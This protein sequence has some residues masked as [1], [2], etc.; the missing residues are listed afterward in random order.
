MRRKTS[1]GIFRPRNVAIDDDRPPILRLLQD[2]NINGTIEVG[3]AQQWPTLF[4]A[5]RL[6]YVDSNGRV[7]ET[8]RA[9]LAKSAAYGEWCRDPKLCA[10]K[11]YCPRDPNCGD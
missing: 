6:G 5:E 8:G 1:C 7:T 11:G 9:F 4:K 2:Q 10:G 3:Y